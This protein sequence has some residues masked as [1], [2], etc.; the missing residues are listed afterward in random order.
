[1]PAD[2]RQRVAAEAAASAQRLEPLYRH[3]HSH[4]ELSGQEEKTSQRLADELEQ[5]AFQVTRRVG[6]YGV[7]AV[8]TNG[9]GPTVLVRTDMDALPL[10]EPTL[11]TGVTALTAAVLDL[12]GR[13]AR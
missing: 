12:L 13:P 7:V 11:K 8:L 10:I 4:P 9:A 5:L 2:L 1:M 6:G 3:F